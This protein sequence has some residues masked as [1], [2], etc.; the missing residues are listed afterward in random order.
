MA[1]LNESLEWRD[2]NARVHD[3]FR[4]QAT[5]ILLE[6]GTLLC[7]FIT[8]ESAQHDIQGNEIFASPWWLHWSSALADILRWNRAH[9]SPAQTIRARMA[10]TSE[11]NQKMNNLA[12]IVLREQVYA[13]KGIARHQTDRN[14]RLTYMGG[15]EQLF[16]PNLAS[17]D[18]PLTSPVAHLHCF[19]D[20]G[21]LDFA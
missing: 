16:L 3:A 8:A 4:S 20:V 1:I 10:V 15:G 13:W 6:H 2:F 21:S 7:R 18:N 11:M 17:R 5:K 19:T 14:R 12:Q 9:A